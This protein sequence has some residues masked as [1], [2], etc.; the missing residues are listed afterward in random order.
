MAAAND[1]QS[2]TF[3][4]EQ[5]AE[6]FVKRLQ[7]KGQTQRERNDQTRHARYPFVIKFISPAEICHYMT[8][9]QYLPIGKKT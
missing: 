2:E 3:K 9:A 1:Q 6:R 4:K 7:Y 5:Q 8:K